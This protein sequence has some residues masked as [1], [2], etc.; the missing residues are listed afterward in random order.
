METFRTF[1]KEDHKKDPKTWNFTGNLK[2]TSKFTSSH[3]KM[4]LN[5]HFSLF[6]SLFSDSI[7]YKCQVTAVTRLASN[8]R[9]LKI[10]GDHLA[11]L[12]NFDVHTLSIFDHQLEHFPRYLCRF[13]PNLKYISVVGCGLK[14]ITA[15]DLV[16]CEGIE[17]LMLNG[18]KITKLTANTFSTFAPNLESISFFNNSIQFVD[19]KAF[20]ELPRLKY[21]NLKMNPGIDWCLRGFETNGSDF[22]NEIQKTLRMTFGVTD[23]CYEQCGNQELVEVIGFLDNFKESA[24][25]VMQEGQNYRA[26][27]LFKRD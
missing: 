24:R 14:S 25:I 5:C 2:K 6:Q 10:T 17:R 1:K 3:N 13:F 16:G 22:L 23:Y 4:E 27:S 18:N 8:G 21:V 12:S 26:E 19:E 11:D 7:I 20:A 9:V 15:T